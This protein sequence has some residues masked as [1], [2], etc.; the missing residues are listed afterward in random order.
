MAN[1]TGTMSSIGGFNLDIEAATKFSE[2]AVAFNKEMPLLSGYVSEWDWYAEMLPCVIVPFDKIVDHEKV[3]ALIG[4]PDPTEDDR[5]VISDYMNGFGGGNF[6]MSKHPNAAKVWTAFKR[7]NLTWPSPFFKSSPTAYVYGWPNIQIN[8]PR[9]TGKVVVFKDVSTNLEWLLEN[10]YKY[11]FV[12]YGPSDETF[13]Y[14][15]AAAAFSEDFKAAAALGLKAPLYNI[16]KQAKQKAPATKQEVV[17][18]VTSL[19]STGYTYGNGTIPQEKLAKGWI[20]WELYMNE[21]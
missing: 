10:S 15:G 20:A 6:D 2:M 3:A 18:W 14:V 11:G 1:L 21:A 7:Y 16:Y 5:K 19:P 12:W 8:D 9:R 17:D 4:K 13:I